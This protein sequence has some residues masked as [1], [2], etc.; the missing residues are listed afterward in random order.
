MALVSCWHMHNIHHY[1]Y[2]RTQYQ[3]A[4][5]QVYLHEAFHGFGLVLAFMHIP[6]SGCNLR[7]PEKISQIHHG[8]QIVLVIREINACALL[9]R[10]V[11]QLQTKPVFLTALLVLTT[12]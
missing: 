7:Y 12:F 10:L 9:L 8:L 5:G 4:D 11:A 1:T 3:G 2:V 6:P